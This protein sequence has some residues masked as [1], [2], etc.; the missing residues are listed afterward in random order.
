MMD[1]R[2][3][4]GGALLAG[5]LALGAAGAVAYASDH[6]DPSP[7]VDGAHGLPA[8]IADL[9]A[10]KQGDD[11]VL[12][13]D[14]AGLVQPAA[15]QSG[16]YD[17]DVLYTLNIDSA[18]ADF[19]PDASIQVRF[20]KDGN[21]QWGVQLLN[22]P[23]AGGPIEGAVEQTL[24]KGSAKAFAGLRDDPFFFDEQGY[25]DTLSTGTLSFDSTRDFF[26]GQNTTAIVVEFPVSAL[27]GAGPHRDGRLN[28]A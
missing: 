24:T 10:W 6:L 17:R 3:R 19:E 8:D 5:V 16:T 27:P 2:T 13:L 26:A 7:R 14:Y 12:V 28:H 20:G 15:N 11:V 18:D 22:V 25:L 9:Y 23:G 1:R 21:G 4:L